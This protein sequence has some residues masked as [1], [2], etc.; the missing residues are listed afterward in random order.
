[1]RSGIYQWQYHNCNLSRIGQTDRRVEQRNKEHIRYITSNNPQ[2][3]YAFHTLQNKKE[4]GLMN[5][6]MFLLHPVHLSRR[7]NLL[8]DFYIHCF[9][10]RSIVISEQSQEDVKPL[11]DLNYDM[12]LNHACAWFPS[13]PLLFGIWLEYREVC[14]PNYHTA[15]LGAHYTEKRFIYVLQYFI[16]LCVYNVLRTNISFISGWYTTYTYNSYIEF[17]ATTFICVLC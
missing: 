5:A 13:T 3:A 7:M 15:L 16:C 6:N 9:Q 12:Q 2:F 4:Y 10:R 8:E 17:M 14:K 1:M 11:F